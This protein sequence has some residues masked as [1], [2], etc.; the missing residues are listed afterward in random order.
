MAEEKANINVDSVIPKIT[1]S[2]LAVCYQCNHKRCCQ[3][4]S[5]YNIYLC[6]CNCYIKSYKRISDLM[7]IKEVTLK[8]LQEDKFPSCIQCD[9]INEYYPVK[10]YGKI[11]PKHY[12]EAEG[13]CIN[14]E[15]YNIASKEYYDYCHYNSNPKFPRFTRYYSYKCETCI[16][17]EGGIRKMF[18][19]Y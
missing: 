10:T 14:E 16:E 2:Y 11:C 12:I 7:A 18:N 15:C 19:L 5:L 4:V 9:S 3:K 13:L 17:K 1:V 6:D 8:M